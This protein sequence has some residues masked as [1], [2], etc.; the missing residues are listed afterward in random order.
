MSRDSTA[1]SRQTGYLSRTKLVGLVFAAT[2]SLAACGGESEVSSSD[3][4]VSSAAQGIMSPLL[5]NNASLS[6]GGDGAEVQGVLV[7]EDDC[8][9]VDDGSSRFPIVW[10]NG[11][12]WDD[13]AQ[14][15]LLNDGQT[16]AIGQSLLGG[17]GYPSVDIIED[18][19]GQ[20]AAALAIEC[21]DNESSEFAMLNNTSDPLE[22][23]DN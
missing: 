16:V 21:L 13:E 1:N 19:V 23:M 12:L 22:I 11:T 4:E 18:L 2:F 5:V 8:L 7:L 20:E 6:E 17:G 9:Y 14:S 3:G 15:V 10:P